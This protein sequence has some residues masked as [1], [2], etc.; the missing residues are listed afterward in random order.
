MTIIIINNNI[1]QRTKKCGSQRENRMCRLPGLMF[2]HT[3]RAMPFVFKPPSIL[4][5]WT[6]ILIGQIS[7]LTLANVPDKWQ[8][9]DKEFKVKDQGQLGKECYKMKLNE[10]TQ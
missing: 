9:K 7:T 1:V 8:L 4:I 3:S 5:G 6:S 10:N 2:G